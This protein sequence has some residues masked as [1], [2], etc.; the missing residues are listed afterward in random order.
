MKSFKIKF[1]SFLISAAILFGIMP[2]YQVKADSSAKPFLHPLFCSHMV[3][4]RDVE[5]V[6]WGWTSPGEKVS[7]EIDGTVS[8]GTANSDGR[9]MASIKPFSKGGP[10]KIRV[11]G[12]STVTIED[13]YFGEVWLC[14]G[15]SNMAMQLPFVLNGD[16]EAANSANTNIRFFT[17]PYSSTATPSD[18]FGYVSSW[19]ICGPNTVG[20]LSGA[21]Y[22]FAKQLT[23]ELDVPIGI[24]NSSVGGSFIESWISNDAFAGF[25]K[26]ANDSSYNPTSPNGFYN[27]MIAPLTP[28]KIKGVMWYQGESNTQ[29]NY[30]YEKQL[31]TLIT[32]WR[33]AFGQSQAPFVVI[34]LPGYQKLQTSPV[35]DAPW[36]II[37]EG[38]LSIAQGDKNVGLV[39]TIDIGEED[40]HPLNKQDLGYRAALCALGKFYGRDI[41]YSGPIYNG[42]VKEGGTIKINFKNTGSGLMAGSKSG[43]EPVKEVTQLKGFAIAG[44]DGNF[45]WGNAAIEGNS[46]IVSS[47]SVAQPV[48]VRYAWANNPIGNLYNKEGLPASPFRT[49]GALETVPSAVKGDINNDLNIDALDFSLIRMHLLGVRELSGDAFDAADVDSSGTVDALDYAILKKYLLGIIKEF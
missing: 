8:T 25:L 35:E 37:R 49:D 20:N 38:Q 2:V 18:T 19:Y 22:F 43:L 29:F 48:T 42:M 33:T 1:F 46:I 26:E 11:S 27:G 7:V 31:R 9:W 3:L 13:V 39:T 36:N 41:T 15:Q 32:D 23:K 45:V 24:I 14:S 30:L 40:I 12:A 5:N 4:Q 28:L 44:S 21:A 34:R 10:Y 47:P 17:T 16:M 6:I